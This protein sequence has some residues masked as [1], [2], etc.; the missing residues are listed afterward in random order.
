[1][2]T[3]ISPM[4]AVSDGNAAIDFYKAA[5]GATLL[6]HLGTSSPDCRLTARSFF[7]R[8]SLHLTALGARARPASPRCGSSSSSTI[9]WRYTSGP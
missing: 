8:T 9:L 3:Q 1:M 5:F 6:W 2:G 4:L 7:S